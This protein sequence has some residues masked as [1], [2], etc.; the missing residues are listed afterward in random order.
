MKHLDFCRKRS[1]LEISLRFPSFCSKIIAISKKNKRRS[2][3]E[4]SL[5]FYYFFL[6]TCDV[7]KNKRK[8]SFYIKSVFDLRRN[9]CQNRQDSA[10]KQSKELSVNS[11]TKV[12][13]PGRHFRDG[14]QPYARITPVFDFLNG[15]TPVIFKYEQTFYSFF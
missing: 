10:P 3:L 1:S 14:W 5:G 9:F 11:R 12:T 6:K 2:S 7:R 8:R 4:I 13:Q 15:L